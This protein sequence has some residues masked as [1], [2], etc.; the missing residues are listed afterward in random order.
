MKKIFFPFISLF[1]SF[2]VTAQQKNWMLTPFQKQD[3]VNPCLVPSKADVT[4]AFINVEGEE[5]KAPA[6]SGDEEED[7]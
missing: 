6:Y 4:T 1:F 3:S 2:T 7:A 5:E